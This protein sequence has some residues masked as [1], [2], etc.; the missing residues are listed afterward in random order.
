MAQAQ[1]IDVPTLLGDA[2]VTGA[3]PTE[4]HVLLGRRRRQGNDRGHPAGGRTAPGKA[5]AQGIAEVAAEGQIIPVG[6]EG[7]TCGQNI[8]KRLVTDFDF[9]HTSIKR[10]IYAGFEVEPMS[11]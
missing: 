11:K 7:T 4:L 9:Q 1:S 3:K 6:F 8:A 2:R 10:L 5:S